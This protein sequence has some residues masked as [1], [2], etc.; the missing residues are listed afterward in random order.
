MDNY[1]GQFNG[2]S[3]MENAIQK[4]S[5]LET[6]IYFYIITL[7]DLRRKHQGYLYISN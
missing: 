6:G 3:N 2:Y 4:N 7:N 1:T 5:G